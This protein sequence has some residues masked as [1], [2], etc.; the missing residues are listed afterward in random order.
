MGKRQ[1]VT[2]M[3]ALALAGCASLPPFERPP[4]PVPERWPGQLATEESPRLAWQDWFVDPTL[5]HL[6]ATALEHNRDLSIAAARVKEARALLGLAQADTVPQIDLNVQ[7]QA[8]R[9]PA[10]L[11]GR[12]VATIS[13]RYDANLSLPAFEL[14]FWGRLSA[15][16]T[17]ARAQFFASEFSRRAVRLA[18]ISDVAQ[19]WYTLAEL[20]ER[21]QLAR[22][23]EASR[24]D[25]LAL[26]RQRQAVGLASELD[27]LLQETSLQSARAEIANLTR[28]RAAAEN[29]LRLLVGRDLVF[30]ASPVLYAWPEPKVGLPAAV[31]LQRP[32]VLAA[33]QKLLAAHANLGAARAAYWPRITLT[34]MA[35]TASA[36]L[37]GLFAGG[38][39]AWNFVPLVKWPIF[40][41]ERREANVEASQAR[42]EI[43][44]AEYEKT[45]Q[46]AFREV[47]DA[48][49]ARTAL[50]EQRAALAAQVT[51]ERER[52][53]RIEARLAVGVSTALE[54]LDAQRSLFAAEQ[55]EI[56]AQAALAR[57]NASLFKTLGG[58]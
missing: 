18:L 42:R 57:A 22:R 17:A 52:I 49:A 53:K 47:A 31:L 21:L 4:A 27:V 6:I 55:A 54:L 23:S 19:A 35:G 33:E 8:A 50:A 56:A 9:L 43:A 30:P 16:E 34:A 12:A 7:Q 40:D 37:S 15:L 14:D 45:I 46:Q 13:R 41:A 2:S 38:S 29:A 58:E 32:D 39:G 5:R 11:A 10:D 26:V 48:L 36:A 25:S 3:L 28:N 1:R 44:L 20:E 51:A 24:A